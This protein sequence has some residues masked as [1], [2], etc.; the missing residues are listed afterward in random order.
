MG[1]RLFH[2]S[3]STAQPGKSGTEKFDERYDFL[4][5]SNFLIVLFR[6]FRESDY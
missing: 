2:P 1:S 5:F 3:T 4:S 6:I